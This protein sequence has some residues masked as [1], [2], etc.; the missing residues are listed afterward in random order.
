VGP[1]PDTLK[2]IG[3][4]EQLESAQRLLLHSAFT[5]VIGEFALQGAFMHRLS[6]PR[7]SGNSSGFRNLFMLSAE[8]H[9]AGGMNVFAS[10]SSREPSDV[11]GAVLPTDG[12]FRLGARFVKRRALEQPSIAPERDAPIRVTVV[13]AG[14]DST[15]NVVELILRAPGAREVLV[16]GDFTGWQPRMLSRAGDGRFGG[17]FAVQANLLRFRVRIDGGRWQVPPGVAVD[18]DEYGD[19]V[20]VAVVR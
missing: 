2:P 19:E 11:L 5:A 16:E 14:G 17:T 7:G 12:R 3:Y 13:R 8:R 15:P 9:I 10:A 6:G 4:D 18:V 20:G 1:R